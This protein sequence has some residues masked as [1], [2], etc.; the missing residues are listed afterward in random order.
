MSIL[1]QSQYGTECDTA[2]SLEH[3]LTRLNGLTTIVLFTHAFSVVN[4]PLHQAAVF[5]VRLIYLFIKLR[6]KL[7]IYLFIKL[8]FQWSFYLPLHQAAFSVVNLPLHQAA[9]FVPARS[10]RS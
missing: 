6:F 7:L 4:L 5:C 1:V 8:R 3:D 9:V 10:Y 2:A